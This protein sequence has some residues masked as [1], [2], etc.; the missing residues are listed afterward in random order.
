VIG[1][2]VF[3]APASVSAQRYRFKYYSHADGLNGLAR[4]R[5][6]R[7]EFINSLAVRG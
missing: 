4:I 1:L 3:L 7:L 2:L 5:N 6:G